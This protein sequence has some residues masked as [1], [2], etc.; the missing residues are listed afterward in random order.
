MHIACS[1]FTSDQRMQKL[2]IEKNLETL[3]KTHRSYTSDWIR[4]GSLNNLR[5]VHQFYCPRS[6]PIEKDSREIF[7]KGDLKEVSDNFQVVYIFCNINSM[8]YTYYY[9]ISLRS[10]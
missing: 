10:K 1:G 2:S 4:E 8:Y 3:K 9:L 6:K 5:D 7:V